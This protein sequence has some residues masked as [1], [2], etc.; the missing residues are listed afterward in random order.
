MSVFKRWSG[1][2][3]EIVG[4]TVSDNR[5]TQIDNMIA[6]EY[7]PGSQYAIND[8]VVQGDILYKCITPIEV[9]GE[10][11]NP[12]HWSQIDV[13]TEIS[14]IYNDI[15]DQ[16]EQ[17]QKALPAAPSVDGNYYLKCAISSGI[18]E[19]SWAVT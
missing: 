9:S 6:P 4:P 11:W 14:E 10:A 2:E 18:V 19:Y 12:A 16:L 1:S 17:I 8:Y 3:W 15:G 7:D 5:I 13:A